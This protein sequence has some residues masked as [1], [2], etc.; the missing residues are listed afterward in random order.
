MQHAPNLTL[1]VVLGT[2][3]GEALVVVN[4]KEDG[5]LAILRP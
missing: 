2:I 3:Q 5:R 1:W 4:V